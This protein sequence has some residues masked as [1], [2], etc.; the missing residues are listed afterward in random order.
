[1]GGYQYLYRK[2]KIPRN[3]KNVIKQTDENMATSL[4]F[5]S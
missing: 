3:N 5:I 2:I 4:L 1:M